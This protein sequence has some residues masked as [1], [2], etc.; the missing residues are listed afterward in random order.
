M[1]TVYAT[2]L[3]LPQADLEAAVADATIAVGSWVRDAFGVSL[4]PL[5]GGT[6]LIDNGSVT[7]SVDAGESGQL[8]SVA[9]DVAEVPS[10][11]HRWR[12]V[13]DI[14]LEDGRGWTRVRHGFYTP[15][16]GL[17][18]RT[19]LDSRRP[20]VVRR[21]IGAVQVRID[22][23][24]LSAPSSVGAD[25]V[26]RLFARL[27]D[28]ARRLPIL[29]LDTI[30][31]ARLDPE[32][33]HDGLLGLAHV[34]VLSGG[35]MPAWDAARVEGE[36]ARVGHVHLYWPSI[37][38]DDDGVLVA[39]RE[40]FEDA[41]LDHLGQDR[42]ISHLY[43]ALGRVAAAAIGEPALSGRLRREMQLRESSQRASEVEAIRTR[44]AAV[45]TDSIDRETWREFTTEFDELARRERDT[46]DELELAGIEI[47]ELRGQL[48]NTAAQ[49]RQMW[50]TGPAPAA[51]AP[52]VVDERVPASALE[53]VEI[54]TETCPHL[55]F[56]PEAFDSARE[57][58][59]PSPAQVLTDLRAI[60][61]VGE[62]W[63]SDE[64]PSGLVPAFVSQLG[65]AYR[66]GISDHARD[67][68][69]ADYVREYE[70]ERV[71]LGPHVARGTGSPASILR[72]YWYTDTT[73][74]RFVVGHIGRKLRDAG[75]R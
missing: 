63:E 66:T 40:S 50:R 41:F 47:D 29:V 53:A 35:A 44:L 59:Y 43:E 71:V 7:W 20:D 22:D 61:R 6:H 65:G 37:A 2:H 33:L 10:G 67:K 14:G 42:L 39:T 48:D 70:G 52:E 26:D 60:E 56:L 57:S 21:I 25:G 73:R 17:V 55:V 16:E 1:D 32:R 46:R 8:I 75:N 74:H 4:A 18:S 28:P 30:G 62:L 64:V 45:Q 51:E 68:F 3:P 5:A 27:S 15:V 58:Q 49:L 31:S 23:F 72:I 11:V 36:G 34:V 38:A 13:I 54:A 12:T 19:P 9:V 69:G 24:P